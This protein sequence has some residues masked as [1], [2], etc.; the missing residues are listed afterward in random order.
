MFDINSD[1]WDHEALFYMIFNDDYRNAEGILSKEDF[2][3][4]ILE[5]LGVKE[6]KCQE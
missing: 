6:K 1:S 3:D 4:I 2:I 5:D